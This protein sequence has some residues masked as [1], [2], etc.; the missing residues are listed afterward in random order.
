MGHESLFDRRQIFHVYE[1]SEKTECVHTLP[2]CKLS[3][4]GRDIDSRWRIVGH[5]KCLCWEP[6]IKHVMLRPN[7]CFPARYCHG[8]LIKLFAFADENMPR[9]S[10]GPVRTVKLS[11][12]SDWQL[13]GY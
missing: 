4:S 8:I 6:N 2:I 7:P 11:H 12:G 3:N 5:M 10:L 1:Y 13:V 9:P